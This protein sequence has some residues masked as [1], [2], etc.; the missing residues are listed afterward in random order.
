M[1]Y[2]RDTFDE[3]LLQIRFLV[4]ARGYWFTNTAILHPEIEKIP[5][6]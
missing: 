2:F 5:L 4:H 3:D 6:N 1:S